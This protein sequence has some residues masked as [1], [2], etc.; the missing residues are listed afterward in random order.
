MNPEVVYSLVPLA[1]VVIG[2]LAVLIPVIGWTARY[3]LKPVAEALAQYRAVQGRD[4]A[5][6][7]LERRF[8]LMEDQVQSLE[9][10]V[11]VLAEEAEFRR[12]LEAPAA[13]GGRALPPG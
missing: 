8:A 10:S 6:L 3:A 9:R 1:G 11:R 4:D 5:T 12:Q 7:L 2:G 13:E